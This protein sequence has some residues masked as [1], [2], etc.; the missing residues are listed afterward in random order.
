MQLLGFYTLLSVSLQMAKAK[1][2]LFM[3]SCIT[4]RNEFQKPVKV[5]ILSLAACPAARPVSHSQC[6]E[7]EDHHRSGL[8]DWGGVTM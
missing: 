2:R 6:T 4:P 7:S 5:V 3:A 1:C 8:G